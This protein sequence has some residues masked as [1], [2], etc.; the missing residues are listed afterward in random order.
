MVLS[1]CCRGQQN[2]Q[3]QQQGGINQLIGTVIRFA[4]MWYAM[5]YFKG[6]QQAATT[7]AGAAAPLY[8]KGDLVDMY[9]YISESPFINIQDRSN[10]ELIWL[11]TEIPLAAG[12]EQ[13][14]TFVYRPT[15]VWERASQLDALAPVLCPALLQLTAGSTP[16]YAVRFMA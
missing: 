5:S 8:R 13:T 9:V 6:G 16:C 3:Q 2:G 10:A 11:K 15:E 1:C 4:L 7:P 12:P 14:A